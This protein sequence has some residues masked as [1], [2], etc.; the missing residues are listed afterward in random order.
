MD[1]DI[2]QYAEKMTIRDKTAGKIADQ[3][4][5]PAASGLEDI[6]F[7]N[8]S[9]ATFFTKYFDIDWNS[10]LMGNTKEMVKE[11]YAYASSHSGDIPTF[12]RGLKSKIGV[13]PGV[14]SLKTMYSWIR[15]HKERDE[16]REKVRII[17]DEMKQLGK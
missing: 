1:I 12:V 6:G 7:K 9:D 13:Q 16:A 2:G 17:N 5:L 10:L 11:I 4:V 3:T 14:N 15:L 8:F